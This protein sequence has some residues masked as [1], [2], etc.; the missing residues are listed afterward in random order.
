MGKVSSKEWITSIFK[1]LGFA[2]FVPLIT[3]LIYPDMLSK[4]GW[5]LMGITL[6]V[7]ELIGTIFN[8]IYG[9]KKI[10]S[11]FFNR[12]IANLFNRKKKD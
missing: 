11:D 2:I 6:F 9:H 5:F 7:I 4:K 10:V 3:Y 8:K 12:K 1:N